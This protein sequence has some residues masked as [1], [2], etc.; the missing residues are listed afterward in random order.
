MVMRAYRTTEH[1][2]PTAEQIRQAEQFK[3][4]EQIGGWAHHDVY[5]AKLLQLIQGRSADY[6]VPDSETLRG[7]AAT[8][9]YRFMQVLEQQQ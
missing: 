9:I 1:Q 8:L 2:E 3:D 4:S 7:E 6:F 5:A